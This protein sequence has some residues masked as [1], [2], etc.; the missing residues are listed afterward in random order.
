MPTLAEFSLTLHLRHEE[1]TGTIWTVLRFTTERQFTSFRY[2]IDLDERLDQRRR[3]IEVR[4]RG[5]RAP[6]N[7]MP[8]SGA[9]TR[10]ICYANLNGTYE[11]SVNGAKQS[12]RFSF[13]VEANTIRLLAADAEDFIRITVAEEVELIRA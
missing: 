8:G 1:A 5:V 10:E 9:A 7:L 6:A 12:G 3:A 13:S 4:L 11:V 2:E